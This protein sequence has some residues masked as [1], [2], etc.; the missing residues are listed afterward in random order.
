[1]QRDENRRSER[2]RVEYEGRVRLGEPP[3]RASEV[4]VPMRRRHHRR[5]PRRLT[6]EFL[7]KWCIG[8]G[9]HRA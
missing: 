1:M 3:E 9:G 2:Q 5:A 4:L 6:A 8:C 7:R